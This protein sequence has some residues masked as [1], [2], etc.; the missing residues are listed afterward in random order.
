MLGRLL[1]DPRRGAVGLLL[2]LRNV[3]PHGYP[4]NQW[5]PPDLVRAE[6]RLARAL[7]R[8][9]ISSRL[10]ELYEF[11][12]R[13]L[14]EPRVCAAEPALCHFLECNVSCPGLRSR[15]D[16][17]AGRCRGMFGSGARPGLRRCV[18]SSGW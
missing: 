18:S 12:A 2:D 17:D 13:S 6:G 8:G 14:E 10:A 7:D 5:P 11:A 3:F 15:L 16:G 4:L 9:I 1:G